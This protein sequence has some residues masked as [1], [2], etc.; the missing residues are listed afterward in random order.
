MK[1]GT[2]QTDVVECETALALVVDVPLLVA[3]QHE[4]VREQCLRVSS[5][6]VAQLTTWA[7]TSPSAACS[8]VVICARLY[9]FNA[10]AT[11]GVNASLSPIIA[12][13]S[14]ITSLHS[15]SCRKRAFMGVLY[16]SRGRLR[17]ELDC[18]L[19]PVFGGEVGHDL[20]VVVC[21]MGSSDSEEGGL[22]ALPAASW[23]LAR[24]GGMTS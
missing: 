10:A 11:C 5:D 9:S 20:V 13:M 21:G 8:T 15:V 14:W 2:Y 4:R 17:D 22:N 18:E 19:D 7:G 3:R 12:A 23:L 6:S 16:F 24:A 1:T